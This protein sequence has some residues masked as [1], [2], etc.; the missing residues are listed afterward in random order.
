MKVLGVIVEYNP[1]HHGHAYHLQTAKNLLK[2]DVTI[3][4]MSGSFLQ[5]GE[6]ALTDK[7]TR[8]EMALSQGVDIVMELPYSSAVQKA[9]YFAEG[10]VAI[11][12]EMGVTDICFGSESGDISIFYRTL[13]LLKENEKI[14]NKETQKYLRTGKSYPRSFSEAFHSMFP[15]EKSLDLTLP[16]NILGYH[17]VKAASDT[18][19]SMHTIQRKGAG[20][21]DEKPSDA[22]S[23][24]SATA[25]RTMIAKGKK[26]Q[27]LAAYVPA[28]TL[29]LLSAYKKQYGILHSWENYYPMLQ[30]ALFRTSPEEL[31][32]IYECE[33]GLEHRLMK[34]RTAE[35]FAEFL[36]NLK[37][38]RYT[39]TR[40]QRLST[41]I[42]HG[43]TKDEMKQASG[44]PS[45]LR[46]LGMNKKGQQYLNRKKKT[47]SLPLL[48]RAGEAETMADQLTVRSGDIHSLAVDSRNRQFEYKR[49]IIIL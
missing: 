7:W 46:L 33:E 40:L 17:Y 21:H 9:D 19:I 23:I 27:S 37:T 10:S 26:L 44:K 16:N 39:R 49:R 14:I 47:L 11:L 41:H 8:A 18:S 31:K 1:F 29:D 13:H 35:S 6:P 45:S 32:G 42:L 15:E 34:Y 25:L 48:S 24:A 20:Y 5:R 4:V 3:A 38:K 22:S 12:K 28:S 43:V 30:Y 2:P 36:D